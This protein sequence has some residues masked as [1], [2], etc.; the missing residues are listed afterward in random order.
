MNRPMLI[1]ERDKEGMTA[2]QLAVF[3]KIASG[4]RK[5][6]PFPF[7][8]MLDSPEVADVVQTVGSVI[9][10]GSKMPADLREVAILAT[11]AAFGSNYEWQYHVA[12][13]RQLGLSE[14]VIKAASL[15]KADSRIDPL[16]A[17]TIGLCWEAVRGRRIDPD[18]LTIIRNSVGRKI[19]T[20]LVLIPGYY[21]LLGLFLS[22]GELDEPQQYTA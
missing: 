16:F 9:R 7:L 11:A 20:E 5:D 1:G 8:A 17:A 18:A 2:Q 13:A 22:A 6:V 4:P 12:I 21:Q 14:E 15:G 10:Y 3:D 19:A